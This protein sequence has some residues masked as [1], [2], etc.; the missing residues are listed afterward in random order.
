MIELSLQENDQPDETV[1]KPDLQALDEFGELRELL[2]AEDREQFAKLKAR[3]ENPQR[4]A[5]DLSS[6]LPDSILLRAK[7]D[8]ALT[9][10]LTPTVEESLNASVKRNPRA[11]ADA[12]FPIIGPAIRKAISN[13]LRELVQSLNQALEYSISIKGVKWRIEALRT[14]KS[15]AE[16]VLSHTLRYRVEQ[17]F[18]I[19]IETGLLL[20]HVSATHTVTQDADM[21]SG[22][23]TAIQDFVHDSFGTKSGDALESLEVGDLQVWIEQGPK[24]LLASVIRGNA[25]QE[26]RRVLQ[27]AIETIHLEQ[28]NALSAFQGEASAF[29]ASRPTLEDC[30]QMQLQEQADKTRQPVLLWAI[31]GVVLIAVAT[32]LFFSLRSQWRFDDYVN[33]LQSEPGI[34][35]VSQERRGGKFHITGLRD[36][37]ASDPQA[38]LQTTEVNP[39][40]VVSRWETYQSSHPDFVLQ[41][42]KGLLQPPKGVALTLENGVLHASGNAPLLWVGE[43]ERLAKLIVGVNEFKLDRLFDEQTRARVE[44]TLIHFNAGSAEILPTEREI[45]ASLVED[46]QAL[47]KQFIAAGKSWRV[48]ISGHTDPTGPDSLN[49]ELQQE[50]ARNVIATL[51]AQG[52]SANNLVAVSNQPMNQSQD[53]GRQVTFK[54]VIVE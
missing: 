7:K 40:T 30:L 36:P 48:E 35:V 37:L 52:V 24:A 39:Q 28:A 5:E 13:A 46:L 9:K 17:V 21:V 31:V 43:A 38:I 6:V 32:W 53:S 42:A 25:P 54:V 23:L 3:I 22:M 16:V 45:M 44:K 8:K 1:Q 15:F 29:E 11:I 51:I 12:I 26:Y 4:R 47:E 49:Q 20:Q 2:L 41:R 27:D 14:G 33:R 50:R 10:A 19:H 18:L 34:V